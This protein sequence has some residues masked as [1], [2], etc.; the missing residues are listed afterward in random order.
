L[1]SDS[2]DVYRCCDLAAGEGGL[3]EYKLS[4]AATGNGR[5]AGG[6]GS[7][8]GVALHRQRRIVYCVVYD[9]SE[10]LCVER[11]RQRQDEEME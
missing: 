2:G 1:D 5:A 10:C 8:G 4:G 9:C 7:L 11:N 3:P 6:C